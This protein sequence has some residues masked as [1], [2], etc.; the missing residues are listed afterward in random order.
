[1]GVKTKKEINQKTEKLVS[2]NCLKLICISLVVDYNQF[3]AGS[4]M[5][6]L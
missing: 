3:L 5:F 4:V 6:F 2:L 1:M